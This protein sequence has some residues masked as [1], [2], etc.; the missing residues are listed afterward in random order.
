MVKSNTIDVKS[1]TKAKTSTIFKNQTNLKARKK[2]NPESFTKQTLVNKYKE[3]EEEYRRVLIENV[4]LR[5]ENESLTETLE[6][7]VKQNTEKTLKQCASI[8]TQT[9]ALFDEAEYPCPNCIYVANC[10]EELGWH[11]QARHGIGD[12]DYEYNHSCRF[13]RKPFDV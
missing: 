3:L 5:K 8:I 13:Y 9:E 10:S 12:P 2:E 6:S 4:Q 11:M 1:L 7:E